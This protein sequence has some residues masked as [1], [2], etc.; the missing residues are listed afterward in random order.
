MVHKNAY[1]TNPDGGDV[2][3]LEGFDSSLKSDTA[4][5]ITQ[6]WI[7]VWSSDI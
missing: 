4:Q 7:E 2:S 5:Q 3:E 6:Q 1:T